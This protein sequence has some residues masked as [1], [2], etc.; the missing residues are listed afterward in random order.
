MGITR[1]LQTQDLRVSQVNEPY[2]RLTQEN[3]IKNSI[4]MLQLI[5]PRES[6]NLGKG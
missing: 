5:S 6:M 3:S 4:Q 1:V 2:I